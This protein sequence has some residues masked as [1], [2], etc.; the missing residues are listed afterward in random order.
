MTSAA[1]L[2]P[3]RTILQ[4]NGGEGNRRGTR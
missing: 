4:Q 2:P 3:R 1:R